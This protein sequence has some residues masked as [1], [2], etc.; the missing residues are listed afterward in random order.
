MDLRLL[1][2]CCSTP[3][4]TNVTMEN[5]PFEDLFP[6]ENGMF[7]CH[8]S[9]WGCNMNQDWTFQSVP[10]VTLSGN[11]HISHPKIRF[12]SMMI[13]RTSRL[14][15]YVKIHWRVVLFTTKTHHCHPC[16]Q[17]DFGHL[18]VFLRSIPVSWKTSRAK[19][20]RRTELWRLVQSWEPRNPQMC[21]FWG[22]LGGGNFKYFLY[23]DP[24]YIGIVISQ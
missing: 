4:K 9:F 2:D 7:H 3:P 20:H 10:I 16:L 17:W 24:S 11:D 15:G 18:L 6:I 8:V 12:E 13:F 14:V 21:L 1:L 5:Q 23:W 19:D 22:D